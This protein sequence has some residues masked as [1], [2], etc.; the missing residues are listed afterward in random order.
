[1]FIFQIKSNLGGPR[2][3]GGMV[4][5][6]SPRSTANLP[7]WTQPKPTPTP[8]YGNN[9]GSNTLPKSNFGQNAPGL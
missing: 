4:P 5:N 2:P 6:A 8:S 7:S 1:M 3:F 9:Y